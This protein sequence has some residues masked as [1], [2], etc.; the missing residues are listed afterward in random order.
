MEI[1]DVPLQ[2]SPGMYVG[3]ESECNIVRRLPQPSSLNCRPQM[4][5]QDT[6]LSL[7]NNTV[8]LSSSK[9]V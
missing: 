2:G 1:A 7:T 8:N 3:W 9:S 4:D 6:A 5:K